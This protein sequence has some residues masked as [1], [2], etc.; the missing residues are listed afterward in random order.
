MSYQFSK[1]QHVYIHWPFCPYKCHFCDFVAMASHEQFMKDYHNALKREIELFEP[2]A[3]PKERLQTIYFGGGT[4]STYPAELLLD[5]FAILNTHFIFDE[6][7]EV[8]IEVNP[9][10]VTQDL[11]RVWHEVGINRLSIGVQSL[12]DIVLKS[13]NRHQTALDVY[14]VLNDASKYF[15]NVSVDFILGLPGVSDDE[16]KTMIQE[17][18]NWPIKHISVY[19][20]MV[21][22]DTPLYFKVKTKKMTLPPDD[23]TVDLYDWTVDTLKA[24]GFDRYE[25]SNFAKPGFESRHN[26]AYWDRKSYKGFGLGACSFNG[27]VR[28]QNGKNLGAY[29]AKMAGDQ[30]P[31]EEVEHLTQQQISLEKIMLGLRQRK[32]LLIADYVLEATEKQKDHFFKGVTQLQ[33]GGFL[34]ESQGVIRLTPKGY[35][36][37]NEVTLRLFSEL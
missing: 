28:F 19:F 27:T 2:Y 7:T 8:T 25:L 26:G 11:L 4:P 9:G 13:L 30:C 5:T 34:Q 15:E 29:L 22:E 32:G 1:L 23:A 24:H 17:A 33:E 16:W 14:A 20:L 6:K 21:Q 10:T 3:G 36:L 12:K 31:I 37:E 35:A 18:M